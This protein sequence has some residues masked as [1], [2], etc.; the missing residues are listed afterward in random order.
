MTDIQ[1]VERTIWSQ[2]DTS[3]IKSF[4]I[5]P[6]KEVEMDIIYVCIRTSEGETLNEYRENFSGTITL[7]LST[8]ISENDEFAV[9]GYQNN[10]LVAEYSEKASLLK[11]LDIINLREA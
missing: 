9:Y 8:I 7:N 3:Q 6:P 10:I 11:R 1:R 2:E 5:R 4:E